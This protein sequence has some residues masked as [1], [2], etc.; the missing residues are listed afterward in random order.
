MG[1]CMDI[2]PYE[3]TAPFDAFEFSTFHAENKCDVLAFSTNWTT[4]DY[5]SP[6]LVEQ[7]HQYWL[8]RLFPLLT[9]DK[10]SYFLAADRVGAEGTSYFCGTTIL[11][12]HTIGS[13]CAARLGPDPTILQKLDQKEEGTI[14]VD[15]AF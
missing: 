1:V 2:N 10:T 13:S 14:L 5:K 8:E 15:L 12:T 6:A 4:D 7:T 9:T 11:F 3:F